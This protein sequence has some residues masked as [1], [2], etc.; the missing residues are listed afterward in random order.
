MADE[1]KQRNKIHLPFLDGIRGIAILGVFFF[2][3]L[4][5]TFQFDSLKW[6][7]IYRDFNVGDSF[8]ALYP[9]T[10]GGS[11]V[12]I[13]FVVSGFCIHL[14]HQRSQES[15]WLSF[16][17]RR[18]FRIYPPYLLALLFFFFVP[19]WGSFHLNSISRI[20][21]L[22]THILAIHNFDEQMFFGIN[23]S[24]WSIAV[25]VQL[26]AL[27]PLLLLLTTKLG[28]K[29]ALLIVGCGEIWIRL[30]VVITSL[31][32]ADSIPWLIQNSP[33]AFW[34]SWSLGAYL[35]EC[36]MNQH[37]SRLFALP[38]WLVFAIAIA[39]P[40]F[41]FTSPFT[42]LV[43]SLLTAI[44]I[45]R[46]MTNKWILPKHRY[47]RFL[48]GH[49]SLLGVV[50]Y[51]FY[52]IHQPLIELTGPLLT[53]LLPGIA[54]HPLQKYLLCLSW[55]PVIFVASLLLYKQLEKPSIQMG[56]LMWQKR[57]ETADQKTGAE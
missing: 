33:F 46:L 5:A 38:F 7:G 36:S 53:Q 24:F 28:W 14:S 22:T 40:L 10:Y 34:L 16:F 30:F 17:N 29:R 12:A 41:K 25:E 2:H 20:H 42:F 31:T 9:F 23:P 27:Y 50:S 57:Q 32:S 54:V 39:V 4:H 37:G 47:F 44:A 1:M 56:K 49:L 35:C 11:G 15:G 55:Y 51:S 45:E 18:F 52:L 13:F 26:Y 3:A 43:F 48:W 6:I 8:L 21:Q 19:P